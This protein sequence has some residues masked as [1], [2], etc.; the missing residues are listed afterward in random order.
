MTL[1]R[2][3]HLGKIGRATLLYPK[4]P[5]VGGAQLTPAK[6]EESL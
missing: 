3:G 1:A 2:G 4:L 5:G 6:K